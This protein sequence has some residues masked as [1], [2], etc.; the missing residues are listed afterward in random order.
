[1]PATERVL[2]VADRDADAPP[3]KTPTTPVASTASSSPRPTRAK[4]LLST[5]GEE[6]RL[7]TGL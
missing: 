6:K 7:A 1:M 2:L 4:A 3:P 5:R